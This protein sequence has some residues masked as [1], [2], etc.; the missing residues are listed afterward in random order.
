MSRQIQN[1][2]PELVDAG[3]ITED[4]AQRIRDYYIAKEED[5]PNR[6]LLVFGTLGA[7]LVGLGIILIVAHNWD[8]LTRTSRIVFAMLPMAIGQGICAY[9]LLRRRPSQLWNESAAVFLFFATAA[10]IAIVSQVYHV[11]GSLKDFLLTWFVLTLPLPYVMRSSAT[12]LLFIF[13]ITVYACVVGYVESDGTPWYYWMLL[14]CVLPFAVSVMAKVDGNFAAF[15]RWIICLSLL[16][17]LGAFDSRSEMLPL[18]YMTLFSLMILLGDHPLYAKVRLISNAFLVVGSI[19]GVIVL[20]T[21]TF[22][23]VWQY[24]S[25]E[26]FV[27]DEGFFVTL[28]LV[29]AAAIML[30]LA[31]RER[32]VRQVHPNSWL[33]LV[34]IVVFTLGSINNLFF[35]WLCN[36]LLLVI[37]VITTRRGAEKDNMV[38]LNYGLMIMTVLI[39][40]RFLDTHM[41]FVVRGILFL[42]VGFSFF[43][44]NYWLLK[45]RKAQKV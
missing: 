25:V 28:L 23:S 29:I 12:S 39:L 34:F 2:L 20:L 7:L 44:A 9:A 38:I 24:T 35:P 14:A 16:I 37:G 40:S 27:Y 1:D 43:A 26:A 18:A 36:L 6:L 5:S 3:V 8:N 30:V 33:F 11:D 45:K 41:T 17:T 31:I 15:H 10:S 22:R 13:G 42:I 21:Y 4:T 19:G 32:G